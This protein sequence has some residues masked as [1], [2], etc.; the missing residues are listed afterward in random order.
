MT[1]NARVLGLSIRPRR[2]ADNDVTDV[3]EQARTI[4]ALG[5]AAAW[6]GQRFDYDSLSMAAVV[7]RAV[8]GLRVGT[9]VVPINP[10]HP[11]VVASQAQTAQAASAGLFSLGLG[12]GAP[13]LE[14]GA[15][16]SYP[17]RPIRRLR[18]YLVV[19]RSLIETGRADLHGETLTAHPPMPTVVRGGQA[20]PLLVA[21]MGPQSLRVTGELADGTLPFLAGPRTIE[22]EILPALT[23]AAQGAGRGAPRV[24]AAVAA[25]VT[26]RPDTVREAAHQSLSFYDAI[27][28][29]RTVMAREGV[30]HAADLALIGDETMVAAG[31]ERYFAAGATE[32]SVTQTDLG[33]DAD[34]QRTWGLIGSLNTAP[35]VT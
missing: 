33:S 7:G 5:V 2:G 21:A 19:L 14:I 6:F 34:Q 27:A 8:P 20:I 15:F 13:A 31:L 17:D 24:V 30:A 29:Y 9:S 18:E 25:V 23:R 32:I 22:T 11:V 3:I 10:R 12:L 28:S 4:Q 26:D 16:G 1:E 35:R